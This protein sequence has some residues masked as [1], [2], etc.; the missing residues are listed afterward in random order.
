MCL[1]VTMKKL[2]VQVNFYVCHILSFF[3]L[4]QRLSAIYLI[5]IRVSCI[6][7]FRRYHVPEL[8]LTVLCTAVAIIL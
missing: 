5:E 4:L 3:R 2:R 6:V 7:T 1:L 8:M